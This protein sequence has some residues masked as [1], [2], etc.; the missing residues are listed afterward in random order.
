[1]TAQLTRVPEKQDVLGVYI[2]K[3]SYSEV[4]DLCIEWARR[5]IAEPTRTAQYICV[6]SVH[7]I[8][9][10]QSDTE[11][12]GIINGATISTPDGM[13]VVWAIRSFGYKAQQR[14]YGPTLM[15][16]I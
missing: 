12:R 16:E 11:L 10:A 6:T 2:S 1:M 15:L 8:I 3:T 13:P 14:V 9:T 4:A 5:R 7:G